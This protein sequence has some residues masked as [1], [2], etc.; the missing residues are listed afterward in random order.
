MYRVADNNSHCLFRGALPDRQRSTREASQQTGFSLPMNI[1]DRFSHL[2]S[3]I[4]S[5]LPMRL[6]LTGSCQCAVLEAPLEVKCSHNRVLWKLK[7]HIQWS[8]YRPDE[9]CRSDEELRG[10]QIRS[11]RF[12]MSETLEKLSSPF[13]YQKWCVFQ[14][15]ALHIDVDFQVVYSWK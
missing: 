13:K 14:G 2:F 4:R 15:L 6:E 8:K 9:W 5:V 1:F 10:K 12:E 11:S 3:R 7:R